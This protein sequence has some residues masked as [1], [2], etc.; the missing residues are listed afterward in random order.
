MQGILSQQQPQEQQQ[1]TPQEPEMAEEQEA[2]AGDDPAL[3]EAYKWVHTKLYSEEFG[4]R[5]S[6][7]IK[8][9]QG[10]AKLLANIA[11]K[12]AQGADTATG[13]NIAEENLVALGIFTLNEVYEIAEASGGQVDAAAL[14]EAFKAMVVMWLQDQGQDTS[15][16]EQAMNAV[17]SDGFAQG[18]EEMVGQEEQ[19]GQNVG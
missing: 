16:I 18:V 2:E 1:A 9:Q 13:G 12:L 8:S 11:Y 6:D 15:Q 4:A 10:S 5:I 14:N 19:G 3:L 7:A 17:P